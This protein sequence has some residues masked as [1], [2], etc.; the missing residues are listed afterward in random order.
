MLRN[1]TLLAIALM[2]FGGIISAAW[3]QEEGPMPGIELKTLKEKA[4]YAIGQ[5]IGAGIAQDGLDVDAELIARGLLDALTNAKPALTEEEAAKVLREFSQKMQAA[6][7]EKAKAASEKTRVAGDEFLAKN[8]KEEGVT[9][10]KSGLQYKKLANG[11]GKTPKATDTVKVHYEGKLLSGEVFDSSKERGEPAMF[12]VNR[13]IA[14]WTEALQLMKE[15]DKWMLYIP[16]ELAYG[17]RGTPG[18]PIGP[19]ETLIFEVELLSV[20]K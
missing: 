7:A 6:A 10:T 1:K 20:G 14:G 2:A 12:P 16:S 9:V 11:K 3:A 5:N 13:V 17:D 8:A 4:S 19:G 18:G 15:G